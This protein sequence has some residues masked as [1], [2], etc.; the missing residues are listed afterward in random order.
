M[1]L[2]SISANDR[3]HYS[4]KLTRATSCCEE[5][6][7]WRDLLGLGGALHRRIGAK[8]LNILGR[9]VGR[10]ERRPYRTRRHRIHADATIDQMTGQRSGKGVDPTL[11]HRIIEQILAA[12]DAG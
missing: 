4:G 12:H 7:S 2:H 3:Q 11:G 1:N 6:E 5:Y 8:V 9:L 10:V